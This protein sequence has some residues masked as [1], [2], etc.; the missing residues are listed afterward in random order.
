MGPNTHERLYIQSKEKW[1]KQEEL[2]DKV[3]K[4]QGYSFAPHT[5]NKY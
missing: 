1:K 4:E 5:N 2:R 3:F